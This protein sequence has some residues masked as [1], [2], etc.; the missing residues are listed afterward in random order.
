MDHALFSF[1]RSVIFGV[2]AR[3]LFCLAQIV[4][5]LITERTVLLSR[6]ALHCDR[7]CT[8]LASRERRLRRFFRSFVY[9]QKIFAP[10]LMKILAQ[11]GPVLL[12][13][14]RT[15]W[16]FGTL[17][18]NFLVLAVAW[19]SIAVPLFWTLLPHQGCSGFEDRRR[20]L[21]KFIVLF[22]RHKIQALMADRE[23]VGPEWLDF[24]EV[25]G[26]TFHIRIKNNT[27]I[28]TLAQEESIKARRGRLKAGEFLILPG[29]RKVGRK[30]QARAYFI[31]VCRPHGSDD[32]VTVI[33]NTAPHQ[34]LERYRRRW[35]IESLFSAMKLRGFALESTHLQHPARLSTLFGILTLAFFW[36]HRVG[37]WIDE[38]RPIPLKAHGRLALAIFRYGLNG[39]AQACRRNISR[40]LQK[41]LANFTFP[42]HPPKRLLALIG[43]GAR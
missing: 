30:K 24:L 14:D 21:W 15:N 26:I 13:L 18:I 31:V 36:A 22:G 23:F 40:H 37:E 17:D 32:F 34:A 9:V 11:D 29:K 8:Q 16:K 2:D 35:E 42:K 28:A 12:T 1:I 33:S 25:E 6:L 3:S 5:A 41:I 10:L 19:K 39:L 27:T 20:L 38:A 7:R 43:Y 4:C